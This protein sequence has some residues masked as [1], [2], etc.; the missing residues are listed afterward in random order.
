M[1]DLMAVTIRGQMP[2]HA[3]SCGL[4]YHKST[5]PLDVDRGDMLAT[6]VAGHLQVAWLACLSNDYTLQAWEAR[7]VERA[8]CAPGYTPRN[9]IPGSIA[10]QSLPDSQAAVIRLGVDADSGHHNGRIYMAGIPET[11]LIDEHLT[12]AYLNGPMATLADLLLDDIVL[13]DGST[14]QLVVFI[15]DRVNHPP[16]LADWSPVVQ[17][18]PLSKLITQRRRHT[19]IL[20]TTPA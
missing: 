19:S 11:V 3:V 17:A 8:V 9:Q 4:G 1:S 10:Q 12:T 2:G 14:W 13:G 6:A 18:T 20:G 5:G 16:N 15:R 7:D